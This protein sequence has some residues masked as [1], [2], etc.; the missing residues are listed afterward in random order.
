M[1]ASSKT[2]KKRFQKQWA[3]YRKRTVEAPKE[4]R[5]IN[6]KPKKKYKTNET[7]ETD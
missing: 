7:S 5:N 2:K 6:I 1:M 3:E 4:L